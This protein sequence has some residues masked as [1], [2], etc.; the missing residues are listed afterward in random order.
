[1]KIHKLKSGATVAI[2]S[3]HGF[4]F[5][6]GTECLEGSSGDIVDAMAAKRTTE[7]VKKIK[8]M[9]VVR[10]KFEA[11]PMCLKILGE[12]CK[13]ADI[14]IVPFLLLNALK[15]AGI[16]EEYP[17]AV[18]FNSTKETIRESPQ[19]KVIDIDNWAY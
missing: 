4:K 7:P 10:T 11:T 1:M 17:N 18:A 16:R 15:E 2:T 12:F 19:N 3:K 9:D 8:G 6:D 5:S 13:E 14:V